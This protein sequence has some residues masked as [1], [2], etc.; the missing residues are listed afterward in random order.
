MAL[1]DSR[2]TVQRQVILL[3][4][5]PCREGLTAHAIAALDRLAEHPATKSRLLHIAVES[6][7]NIIRHAMKCA[8]RSTEHSCIF[9]IAKEGGGYTVLCGNPVRR[10]DVAALRRRIEAV[11]AVDRDGLKELYRGILQKQ[12]AG[13]DPGPGL[14]FVDMARRSGKKLLY[15]FQEMSED[16]CFFRMEITVSPCNRQMCN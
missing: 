13:D 9:R 6:I 1:R 4:E 14:G 10:A 2:E 3:H 15:E 8:D 11:N 16:C 12:T 7:Q 5:G